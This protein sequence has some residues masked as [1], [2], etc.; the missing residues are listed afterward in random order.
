MCEF[1]CLLK[2]KQAKIQENEK[3]TK[4][5]KHRENIWKQHRKKIDYRSVAHVGCVT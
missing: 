4:L 5:E 3:I 1:F 2:N